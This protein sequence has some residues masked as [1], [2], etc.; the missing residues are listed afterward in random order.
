[1][2]DSPTP[3]VSAPPSGARP[4]SDM[5]TE[6]M[7][8]ALRYLADPAC[9]VSDVGHWC[10]RR[11]G[12]HEPNPWNPEGFGYVEAVRKSTLDAL[13]RRGLLSLLYPRT[14]PGVHR[15]TAVLTEDGRTFAARSP[16]PGTPGDSEEQR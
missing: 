11:R 1:M 6:P 15:V 13:Q 16:R 8:D 4:M 9:E 7:R 14:T 2:T 5:L 12:L 10:V 3:S